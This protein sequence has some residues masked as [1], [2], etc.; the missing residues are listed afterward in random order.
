MTFLSVSSCKLKALG[1]DVMAT[2][3]NDF[4]NIGDTIA[5]SCPPGRQL[6]GESTVIC[7]ASL[8]LSPDPADIK[9]SPGISKQ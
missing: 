8:N 7:D 9:C 4:Y 6:I 3:L 1:E 2:P 5:L